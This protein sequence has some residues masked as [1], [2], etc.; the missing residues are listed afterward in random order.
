MESIPKLLL[1]DIVDDG[2]WYNCE[3]FLVIG[4]LHAET[5]CVNLSTQDCSTNVK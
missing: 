3:V 1:N 5:L 2:W 4:V